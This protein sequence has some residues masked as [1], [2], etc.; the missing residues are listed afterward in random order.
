MDLKYVRIQGKEL[1]YVTKAP[2]GVFSLCWRLI[3]DG[4]MS[5]EDAAIF[6]ETEQWFVDHLPE[7]PMCTTG[8]QRVICYFKTASTVHMLDRLQPILELLDKYR[9][10][11]DVVYTN[12]VGEVVYEDVYQV[13]VKV[14][15]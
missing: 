15:N 6:K 12:Y 10:P 5:G 2:K 7:P 9:R 11:Y 1:S 8:D 13:A 4:I 14:E 3:Y